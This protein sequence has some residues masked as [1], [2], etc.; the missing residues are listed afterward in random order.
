MP[1]G[2]ACAAILIFWVAMTQ[3]LVRNDLVPNLV[4]GPPPDFRSLVSR[5][6]SGATYWTLLAIDSRGL[7]TERPVGEV[8]TET[9]RRDDGSLRLTSSARF[10]PG[11]ILQG[12]PIQVIEGTRLEVLGSCEID[13]SGNLDSFRVALR[14]E[15]VPPTELLTLDGHVKADKLVVSTQSLAPFLSGTRELPYRPHGMVQSTLGPLDA[16]PGLQVGQRWE[17]Q[18]V[19][20]ITGKVETSTAEVV[21]RQHIHWNQ[22][23]VPT[24]VIVTRVGP[25]SA[26]TWVRGD[27]LVLRQEV[28]LLFVKLILERVPDRPSPRVRNVP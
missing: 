17:S 9:H 1:S 8:L 19:N 3:D 28:P 25:V 5:G 15:A 13:R 12:T 16:M 23:P 21:G 18:V 11:V 2:R 26:R 4:L 27:G 7:A 24:L 6:S 14:E 10:E 20:P 22:N